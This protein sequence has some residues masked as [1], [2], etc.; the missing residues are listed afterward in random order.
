MAGEGA[1]SSP[2]RV[3]VVGANVHRGWG[4]NA[5]LPAL[6]QLPELE[7]V[8]V[9][10]TRAESARETAE[11]FG[12]PLAFD[13]A[14]ALI[15]H[16]DVDLVAVTVKIP[17]HAAVV[18]AALAAGK[19]VFSEWPLGVDLAETEA[20]AELAR[21]AGT[22]HAVGLQ[23]LH[24]AGARF[25]ADLIADGRIG[26][27]RSVSLIASAGHGGS[28]ISQERAW[29]LNPAAGNSIL[30]IIGGHVLATLATTL[31]ASFEQLSAVVADLDPEATVIETGERIPNG[32]PDQVG[33]LGTLP[34]G[35][36]V[37][38][39]LQGGGP[40]AV[41]G[42][43]LQI[44]GTDGALTITPEQPGGA[45]HIADWAIRLAPTAGEAQ[46]LAVPD[47]YR[48]IPASVPK[49][50]PTNVAALYREIAAAI[51][52]GREPLP[53]FDSAVEYHRLLEAIEVASS[54][55]TRQQIAAPRLVTS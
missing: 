41:A 21:T 32:T 40:P 6:A 53:S 3:G 37:S 43:L 38:I 45:L 20:L 4:T 47:S 36:V 25:V 13:S 1:P 9:A 10:T 2:I 27:L 35:A 24:S 52:E 33:L 7:V 19:H 46:Q 39:A 30:T 51:S 49:G 48:T 14:D 18:R 29:T 54:T 50:P 44:V 34:G 28:R 15:V 23:G 5:H 12:V 8:A 26:A 31:G 55:G 16:Q 42:F 11:R 17:S 22:V